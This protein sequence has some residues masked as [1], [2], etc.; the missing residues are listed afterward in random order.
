MCEA[1]YSMG[2]SAFDLEAGM[3]RI[4]AADAKKADVAQKAD[5]A[6]RPI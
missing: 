6:S 2:E 4:P 3:F 1:L 5:V